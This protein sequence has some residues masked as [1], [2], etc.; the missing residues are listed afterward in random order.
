M[1]GGR[2]G[3]EGAMTNRGR[4]MTAN[5]KK[6]GEAV[7]SDLQNSGYQGANVLLV[8]GDGIL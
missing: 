2:G 1:C 8:G 5:S 3:G 7:P 4:P 6:I